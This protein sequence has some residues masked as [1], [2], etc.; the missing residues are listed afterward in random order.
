MVVACVLALTHYGHAENTN[1]LTSG[2]TQ[3]WLKDL[4]S[5]EVVDSKGAG[6]P[7]GTGFLVVT[8]AGH[9]ALVTAK[10]VVF[11]DEG[12][13][14]L[15]TNLGYRLNNKTG[16]SELTPDTWATAVKG[17]S[18]FRSTNS[19]VACRLIVWGNDADFSPIPMSMFL[20]AN[21]VQA[22]APVFL[23]GFPLG[24]R[25]EKYTL[26]ILR[27][28]IV[29]RQDTDGII[30]DGFVFP[31]NSGGPVVYEPVIQVG[32]NLTTSLLQGS[33]LVGLVS[34]E[35]SYIEPAISPQTKRPRIT[36]ESNTGLCNIVPS[37]AILELL[38]SAEF[39][40]ADQKK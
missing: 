32:D 34:S 7:I 9:A 18:W 29:A 16:N 5:I 38:N 14:S 10:H 11:E 31:G 39:Q 6:Q 24:L 21:S 1:K 28:G 15:I 35:I 22:G 8:P 13:G 27:K 40:K 3:Q 26:P 23:I 4:V 20:K 17:S 2:F 37:D 36:F 25:S 33:W 12:K 19:D 30:V